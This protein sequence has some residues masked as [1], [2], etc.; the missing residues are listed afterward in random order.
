VQAGLDEGRSGWVVVEEG[1]ERLG[2]GR[3]RLGRQRW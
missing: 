1:G 2:R 3:S